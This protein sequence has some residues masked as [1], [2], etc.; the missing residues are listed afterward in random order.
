[1]PEHEGTPGAPCEV[2]AEG[3]KAVG[4][5]GWT[6]CRQKSYTFSFSVSSKLLI[7]PPGVLWPHHAPSPVLEGFLQWAWAMGFSRM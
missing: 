5:W 6:G 4:R 2:G 3:W 1:M 7:K